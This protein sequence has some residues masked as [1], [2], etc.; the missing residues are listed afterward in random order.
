M[1]DGLAR[2][3]HVERA[4]GEGEGILARPSGSTAPMPD[5][6]ASPAAGGAL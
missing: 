6:R 3:M 2:R 1:S 4:G 5:A